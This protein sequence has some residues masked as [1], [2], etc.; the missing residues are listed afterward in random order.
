MSGLVSLGAAGGWSPAGGAAPNPSY[1]E[2]ADRHLSSGRCVGRA[3]VR[4]D[5]GGMTDDW[6]HTASRMGETLR[7]AA[8]RPLSFRRQRAARNLRRRRQWVEQVRDTPTVQQ[9]AA[10]KVGRR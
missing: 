2:F 6:G 7:T 9:L 10:K 3:S 4:P 5:G 8:L 1:Q